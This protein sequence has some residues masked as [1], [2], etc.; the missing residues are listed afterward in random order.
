M[1]SSSMMK[2]PSPWVLLSFAKGRNKRPHT[3]SAASNTGMCR[4]QMQHTTCNTQTFGEQVS[5]IM[6]T[7]A[8]F[9]VGAKRAFTG[10]HDFQPLRMPRPTRRNEAQQTLQHR[11][12]TQEGRTS[13]SRTFGP[14]A[15]D[16]IGTFI[17]HLNE[18]RNCGQNRRRRRVFQRCLFRDEL[19]EPV[20]CPSNTPYE[21]SLAQR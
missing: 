15:T 20:H 12:Y 3:D 5:H 18:R 13:R 7:S 4:P 9:F 17:R 11:A 1:R 21:V 16:V 14:Y 19:D 10:S 2:K 8:L 6:S